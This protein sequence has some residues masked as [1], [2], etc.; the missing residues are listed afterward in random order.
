MYCSFSLCAA[1]RN[2]RHFVCME[3]DLVDPWADA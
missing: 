3:L 2:I 1:M